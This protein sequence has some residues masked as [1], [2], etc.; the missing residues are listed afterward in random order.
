MSTILPSSTMTFHQ[1]QT[2]IILALQDD[3]IRFPVPLALEIKAWSLHLYQ[4]IWLLNSRRICDS[5]F[6]IH[7]HF[8]ITFETFSHTT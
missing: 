1:H 3:W 2:N 6:G 8:L 4:Y 7:K 5:E